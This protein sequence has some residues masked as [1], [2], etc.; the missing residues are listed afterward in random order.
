MIR[1]IVIDRVEIA[2]YKFY[3]QPDLLAYCAR[4][5]D[6]VADPLALLDT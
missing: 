6:I 5:V 1:Q 3:G 2:G 4:Q